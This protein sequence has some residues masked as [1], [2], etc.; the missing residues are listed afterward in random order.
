MLLGRTSELKHL[1]SYYDQDGSQIMVVYGQRNVG[2]T[3]LLKYFVQDKPNYYYKVRSGSEREQQYQWGRELGKKGIKMPKY[4][5]YSE[6][7]ESL[8]VE[9]NAKKVIVIDEFQY[10]VKSS[11]NFMTEL[12]NF[13]HSYWQSQ[14]VMIVL[15]SSSIGWVENSMI[16]KIGDAAY[17]LS[18]FLK[19]K[20]LSFEYMMEFF[21]GFSLEQCIESYAVLGGVPGLWEHFNDKS[22]LKDNICKY[23]LDPISFLQMEGQRI[24]EEELRETGVYNSILAAI[25][26]GHHK[27]N[28]LYVHT[29]FSR[30]KIS[31]YLKNLIELELVEKVF[32][33][34][35]EG[36]ENTQKGIY[37]ISN[38]FVNFYFTYIYP[39]LTD[40]ELMTPVEFYKLHV[41]NTFKT[42]V[43]EYFK[44]V[45]RQHIEKWNKWNQLPISVDRIGEWVGKLG[46]IDI[47]AQNESGETIVGIC[48]WDKPLMRYDDYEWLLFCCK[49]AKIRVDYIYLFSVRRFDEK[50]NLEAKV[51]SNLKLISLE[52]M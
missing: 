36:K 6:I 19:I 23:I 22:S 39:N 45:C 43:A 40:L 41:V 12:I 26:Q 47:I 38:H 51:K 9:K 28:D 42:Y 7:F 1:N 2:K 15:I 34:D 5:T 14:N 52:D 49:E 13:V 3:A 44:T 35:T 4:P 8:I 16:N 46:N 31:V 48:N 21:P 17:E 24:V 29:E 33:Y 32:S 30:A 18:S 50:L 10:L 37:R 11:D 27:L 20:E 25:A